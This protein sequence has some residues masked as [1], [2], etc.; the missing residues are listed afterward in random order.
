MWIRPTLALT[1]THT[2]TLALTL[3]LNPNPNPGGEAA[4]DVDS[5]SRLELVYAHYAITEPPP[6]WKRGNAEPTMTVRSY[7]RCRT[8]CYMGMGML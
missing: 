4:L 5:S 6:R 2:L 3:T 8:T 7:V 1:H